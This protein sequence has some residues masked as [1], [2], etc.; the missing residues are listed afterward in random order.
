MEWT[1]G[2]AEFRAQWSAP[3]PPPA[4]FREY[5]ALLPGAT[6]RLFNL[7]EEQVNHRIE[8]EQQMAPTV[9]KAHL[10]G[11]WMSYSLALTA[12]VLSGVMAV[13]GRG[14]VAGLVA[15]LV[16]VPIAGLA[17]VLITGRRR[18][19]RRRLHSMHD[20]TSTSS[21]KA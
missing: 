21:E 10:R 18:G 14:V 13:W 19:E 7:H 4:V 11:Q 20:S 2:V 17:A 6:Q 12:L 9:R 3:L 15:G 16:I 8:M 1:T 5:E